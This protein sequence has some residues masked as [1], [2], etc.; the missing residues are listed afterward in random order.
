[1]QQRAPVFADRL[2]AHAQQFGWVYY[3]YGGPAFGAVQ[4]VEFLQDI[5]RRGVDPAT[6]LQARQDERAQVLA[7]RDTLLERLRPDDTTRELLLLASTFVWAKPRRKDYQSRSYCDIEILQR[8]L[9]RR[10]DVP[11]ELVRSASQPQLAAALE[12]G[13]IDASVLRDQEEEH[14]ILPEQESIHILRGADAQ[15]AAS[16]FINEGDSSDATSE[17]RGSTAYPGYARGTV[18]IVNRPEDVP[19][20]NVGDILVSVATTPSIILA[21]KRAA[22]IVTD[23]GGLTCHAAIVSRELHIPCVVGTKR[24]TRALRDGDTVEVD[25]HRGVVRV[26]TSL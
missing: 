21:M 10:L 18:R 19:N 24:A 23:E 9:S 14:V 6:E 3:V 17:L 11:L 16:D 12:S 15:R 13:T 22:A 7:E 20:V 4:F 1:L 26:L 2:R 8:E 25:A 5:R